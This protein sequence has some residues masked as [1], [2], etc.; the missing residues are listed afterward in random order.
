MASELRIWTFY[1]TIDSQLSGLGSGDSDEVHFSA[2]LVSIKSCLIGTRAEN[3]FSLESDHANCASFGSSNLQTM[4]SYLRDLRRAAE[5]AEYLS[6]NFQH[7]PLMLADKVKVELIGFFG[8]P[9][10]DGH[11]DIRLYISRH[12]LREFLDKGPE[13]CLH[14]RLSTVAPK[15]RRAPL[16]PSKAGTPARETGV[17]GGRNI[18]SN[19]QEIGSRLFGQNKSPP[20][21]PRGPSHTQSPEIVVTSH[22]PRPS[23][24]G[25]A[26][27]PQPMNP[28]I[29]PRRIRGLPVPSLSPPGNHRPPSRSGNRARSISDPGGADMFPRTTDD[30]GDINSIRSRDAFPGVDE[31]DHQTQAAENKRQDISRDNPLHELT[32]DFLR[33]DLSWRKF[34]W[35]HLPFN[36]PHWV[37]K[38]FDKLSET[39]HQNYSKLLSNDL[40]VKRHIQGRHANL[41]GAYVKP[42]CAFVPAE[43]NP[44]S[45]PSSSSSQGT[46]R[47][48]GI[49]PSHLYLYM[50]YL[51]FDTYKN[52]IR[53]RNVIRR[54]M[55][56]GRARPVPQDIAEL[57]SLDC[58]VIWEYI[59]HDPPLNARR[60]LDQYGYPALR[61]TYAR[62]D[63][64]MLYK[65]T[66][67]RMTLLP[68]DRQDMYST[69][70]AE[71]KQP[72]I[73]SP[74]SPLAMNADTP[75]NSDAASYEYE[76]DEDLESDILDGN[77]LMVDQ[78]WL[79]AIDEKTLTT[80]FPKRE[81]Y[82]TEGPM[83]QQA[84][85]RNSV[86]HELNG[87]LTG[88]CETALDLAAFVV[89]HAV[90]VLLDRTSHPDLEVFRIFEEA[91]GIL[92]ERMTSSLK[93]FRM[94][95]F[96]DNKILDESLSSDTEEGDDDPEDNR[97]AAIKRRHRRELEQ[98]ERENRENT[99]A[100]L[101]LR[102]MDDELSTMKTLF[103]EQKVVIE[104]MLASYQEPERRDL[105]EHGRGFLV[106]ALGRL[107]EYTRQTGDMIERVETTRKDYEKLLEM[108]QRQAQ[109]DEVRWSRLQ[110]ELA[111]SQNLSV[112]IFTT[113]TVIFLPLSFFT[114]LFGMNTAEWGGADDNFVS[115]RTIGAVSLPASAGLVAASLV[116]AFSARAQAFCKAGFRAARRAL[117]AVALKGPRKVA[118][119]LLAAA[120]AAAAAS[121]EKEEGGG[122]GQGSR[123]GDGRRRGGGA[124][125]KKKTW[126][127]VAK[128]ELQERR[129]LRRRERGYD[130]WETEEGHA[131]KTGGK[132]NLEEDG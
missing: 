70:N 106:E 121:K 36:N 20:N 34:M 105:T 75:L 89:L 3:A 31:K 45:R 77:V 132:G 7:T 127:K 96:R 18:W 37:N 38:I 64:Q 41:Q 102:D 104:A 60:T 103:A 113:F 23:I 30:D 25:A 6:A 90:T 94:Q 82:P 78:L 131:E 109:V 10:S 14:E 87:D 29:G 28:V 97:S 8:D 57:E 47:S 52:I 128:E 21:S 62:D 119:L 85:L 123:D 116:L 33:P 22:P 76:S 122:E 50:P 111:S 93:R 56:H 2:P 107:E 53:R 43:S 110:T 69:R 117:E 9:K 72:P 67:E 108:V 83:F 13:Q 74:G 58:R 129:R 54:R 39:N 73:I 66:K 44:P 79:W 80:F 98:A 32:A 48:H 19:V 68:K 12:I 71:D 16:R 1:E 114:S 11:A 35:I 5:K 81:S 24:A 95:T 40:W 61:D 91:I 51:H 120:A 92:S 63:D 65:L 124:G 59:G 17:S 15:P 100:L 126:N 118:L 4:H 49:S 26:T 42:G 46:S 27:E 88:R 55:S 84:D 101:E 99:S 115:L 130:F 86:Y 112:M 125:K